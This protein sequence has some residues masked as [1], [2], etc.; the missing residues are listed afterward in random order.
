MGAGIESCS[1]MAVTSSTPIRTSLTVQSSPIA[2]AWRS[3]Q[4]ALCAWHLLSLDAPT[5][6]VV[7]T[8]FVAR[9]THVRLPAAELVALFLAV[10]LLY[11]A[12]RLLDARSP[13][14]AHGLQA[15]HLFHARYQRVFL[16][17]AAVAAMA[18]A[19]LLAMMP[20]ADRRLDVILAACLLGWFGLIHW[21]SPAGALPKELVTGLF[22]GAAACIPALTRHSAGSI[23]FD[24]ALFAALCTLNGLLISDWEQPLGQRVRGVSPSRR[25]AA[26]ASALLL[27]ILFAFLF[28]T[29]QLAFLLA[30]ALATLLLLALQAARDSIA[31]TTLRACAD[32][33]LLTPVFFWTLLR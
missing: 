4:R 32:L 3:L 28:T 13:G 18:L 8:A 11:V 19:S 22:F 7:W 33:V 6:A 25:S 20:P 26:L 5:V 31:P 1:F 15:R 27:L 2:G 24:A 17:T 16:V 29:L 21:L 12:D 30:I 9:T 10:W 14:S 23:A